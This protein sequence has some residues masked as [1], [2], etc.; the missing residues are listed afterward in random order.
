MLTAEQ[1]HKI[2]SFV[3]ERVTDIPSWHGHI[4]FSI[5][6]MENLRPKL[7]VELGTHKG[8]SY[9][10]FCQAIQTMSLDTR[11][12]AVDTW[13]GDNH[14]GRYGEDVHKELVNYHREKGYDDF[15]VLLRMTFDQARS[16]FKDGTIDL[17]HI[18]GHHTYEDVR[19]DFTTW[20]PKMSTCG[21]VLFHD[22]Q[23]YEKDFGVWRFYNEIKRQY[24]HFSFYHSN[25][26]GVV[27]VGD[28]QHPT[29]QG[30]FEQSIDEAGKIRLFFTSA[31][32]KI[33][34]PNVNSCPRTPALHE[35]QSNEKGTDL[36]AIKI[37]NLD[38][39]PKISVVIPSYNHQDYILNAV[40]SV[41]EQSEK[42]FELIIIDDGSTD[43]TMERLLTISDE[44][45][46]IYTQ[47]N[48]GAATTIN[49]A[50]KL[51]RG[52]YLSILNSDD[53]YAPERLEKLS[54]LLDENEDIDIVVT[55][56]HPID[57]QGDIVTEDMEAGKWLLWYYRALKNADEHPDPRMA[58]LADN[59]VV[60]TSNIFFRR[61]LWEKNKGF[62]NGLKYCHDYEYLLRIVQQHKLH[63][64]RDFLLFY[65]LHDAN[66]IVENAFLKYLEMQ[67]VIFQTI[68]L[69][70][71]ISTQDSYKRLQSP[72][73]NALEK[74]LAVNVEMSNSDLKTALK[75]ATAIVEEKRRQLGEAQK[76]IEGL[77]E[78]IRKYE[79][80]LRKN[81]E[82]MQRYENKIERMEDYCNQLKKTIKEKEVRIALNEN[83]IEQKNQL[84]NEI[85]T[86]K[87][88]IWLNRLRRIKQ[89]LSFKKMHATI[90]SRT[91]LKKPASQPI[92]RKE[93]GK[94]KVIHVIANMMTGGS[95]RLVT[96]LI[97]GLG[98]KY[99]QEVITSKVPI[100]PVY[101]GFACQQ[102]AY[103][104]SIQDLSARLMSGG[105]DM[106]H[107]HYWG[108]S[109]EPWYRRFFQA[110]EGLPVKIIENINT[111][112][113]PLR[114]PKVDHYVF[115]SR[116]AME[117]DLPAPENASVI[118][119]GSD[120][121]LFRRNGETVPDNTIGMVYR[122][123]PD[124]LKSDAIDVFIKV[125]KRR[126]QTQ[127][128]IIGG[129]CFLEIYKER[130][131]KADTKDNFIFSDYVPYNKLP[132]YYKKMSLF[133][134][135]VWK[136]SFGQV[137]PFAMSMQIPV[138]G[139]NVGAL[140]EILDGDDCLRE[141]A[142]DLAALICD[143]LDDREKRLEIG[144]KNRKRAQNHF[145]V[146]AMVSAYD[147]LYDEILNS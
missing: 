68:D 57:A 13:Q 132:E 131:E 90:A 53:R 24:P 52:E 39:I 43:G 23:V 128:Y 34:A 60:T 137:S 116:Y 11:C 110:A 147:K 120:F 40:E 70:D 80:H 84:L 42:R 130:V 31:G 134:A 35:K 58:L 21:V 142:D 6:L 47:S 62:D 27:G 72:T 119:P 141:N 48:M 102:I 66:T 76:G 54:R 103:P 18:D 96:D 38:A 81:K 118:Y 115:V 107:V 111:P 14:S 65:R 91:V 82:H 1:M 112:V 71:L 63:L 64:I 95:S 75:T 126:P 97:E 104:K 99:A 108:E 9:C 85:F 74:N 93:T 16:E 140:S 19:H 26:L 4:P 143:L 45:V 67:Y 69:E 138:V 30:L 86:S 20:L 88:W 59:F 105:T 135:P 114:H 41:L 50:L 2:E 98:E 15:S 123:E 117:Y 28:S 22:T 144:I 127:C 89:V 146:Q 33:N 78:H 61:F 136:E 32:R 73:I 17:L 25:G 94:P 55:L 106:I 92:Y 7:F 3:P 129:G 56:L 8:D 79:E 133:V 12:F 109:D 113:A 77:K 83:I 122:L 37:S 5:W 121:S 124:K 145:S 101:T 100:P 125:V 44:R 36:Q 29:I 51:A 10:A 49:R 139:Y 46:S 87:G